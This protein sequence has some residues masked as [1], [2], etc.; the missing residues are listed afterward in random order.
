MPLVLTA[1]R[2][3][4]KFLEFVQIEQGMPKIVLT[5]VCLYSIINYWRIKK[6]VK[7]MEQYVENICE[8]LHIELEKENRGYSVPIII[9]ALLSVKTAKEA[10][11]LIS[12]PDRTLS[13]ILDEEFPS[14]KSKEKWR[15]KLL[16]LLGKNICYTCNVVNEMSDMVSRHANLCKKC[17][18]EKSKQY[19]TV[20]KEE[21]LDRSREHYLQNKSHYLARNARRRAQKIHATPGWADQDKIREIYNNCPDGYHVDHIVPLQGE[22]VSGLH[23]E[24]NLQ[25]L[26]AEENLKKHNK[27]IAG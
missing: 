16:F 21:C 9:L 17:D 24:Y 2:E 27:F 3:S 1:A 20:H 18:C 14:L 5:F 15:T 8:I 23:V 26:T 6:D 25:Y 10:A 22:L 7:T 19:R 12:C 11:A 13:R 4:P